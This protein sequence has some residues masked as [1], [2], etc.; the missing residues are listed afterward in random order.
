MFGNYCRL[1]LILSQH[2]GQ[3]ALIFHWPFVTVV[4][5]GRPRLG[6]VFSQLSNP[7]DLHPAS[8]L[9]AAQS[10]KLRSAWP[11]RQG[12]SRGEALKE[13]RLLGAQEDSQEGEVKRRPQQPRTGKWP[14]GGGVPG[15][16][17]VK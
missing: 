5:H 7:V 15:P 11:P 9:P 6:D 2:L 12:H 17:P 10:G 1:A 3:G 8:L 13:C 14:G 4:L 16:L